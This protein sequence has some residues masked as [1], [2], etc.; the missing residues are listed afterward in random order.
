MID[1]DG[2]LKV[3]DFGVARLSESQLTQVG[4]MIGT[5]SYMA[6]EQIAGEPT[7]RRTDVFAVGV[8]AYKLLSSQKAFPDQ[9]SI[10]AILLEDPVPLRISLPESRSGHRSHREDCDP[11]GTVQ[12]LR[13]ARSDGDRP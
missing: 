5:P 13:D 9:I 4:A 2:L 3:L 8:T 10:R 12:A 6:P 1:R 11:K 7:D